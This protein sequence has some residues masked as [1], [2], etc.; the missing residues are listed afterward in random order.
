MNNANNKPTHYG[1]SQNTKELMKYQR[2]FHKITLFTEA[3]IRLSN[4]HKHDT[5][6]RIDD[7]QQK[8]LT[9]VPVTH[10]EMIYIGVLLPTSQK[11]Q[12]VKVRLPSKSKY[13]Q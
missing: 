6:H 5:D 3:L 1:R 8:N 7:T 4:I 10:L 9:S 12:F 11:R 2:M 13:E